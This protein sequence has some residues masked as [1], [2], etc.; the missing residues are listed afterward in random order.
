MADAAQ[1]EQAALFVFPGGRLEAP[2]EFEYLR[3]S[4]YR[5][6]NRENVDGLICW[7]SSLGGTVS[8]DEVGRY[9]L[10]FSDIP[11]VTVALKLPGKPSIAFDAYRGMHSVVALHSG[12]SCRTAGLH[13]WPLTTLRHKIAL[14]LD[15]LHEHGLRFDG[16]LVSD[17][18][19][20]N[21]G[22]V[23]L[24]NLIETRKLIPGRDF[25]TLV[26]ASDLLMLDAAR[27][28]ERSGYRIPD[29]IRVVGFNDSPESRFMSSAGTTVRVPFPAMG[30]RAFAC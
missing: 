14:R 11:L 26:C 29:D 6:V 4:I 28:L 20:W 23:A 19:P 9:L 3:N 17:P 8:V 25:D 7:G 12:P 2:A 15:A 1:Q 21:E 10:R 5:L 18:V 27:H 24:R 13:P 16:L 30:R 22:E